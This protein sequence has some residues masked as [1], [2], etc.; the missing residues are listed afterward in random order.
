M[1]ASLALAVALI[2]LLLR[3][4][5]VDLLV[6]LQQLKRVSLIAFAKIALLNVLWYFFPLKSGG[7]LMLHG[8][9]DSVQP[10]IT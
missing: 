2:V 6:T 1:I 4:G 5:K 3:I 7:A 10:R 9:T 8:P